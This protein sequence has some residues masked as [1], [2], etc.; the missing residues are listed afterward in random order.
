MNEYDEFVAK[1]SKFTEADMPL[2][3]KLYFEGRI[4]G[5]D[6]NKLIWLVCHKRPEDLKNTYFLTLLHTARITTKEFN[7]IVE[8]RSKI[9]ELEGG[10][11]NVQNSYRR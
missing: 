1:F 11:Y 6:L 7:Q 8:E 9:W 2:L 3:A 10:L 4:F 5:W